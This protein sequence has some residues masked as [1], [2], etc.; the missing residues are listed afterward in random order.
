MTKV[1]ESIIVD[2]P[3]EQI[4]ELF[5]EVEIIPNVIS[6]VKHVTETG[7]GLSRWDVELLGK[8]RSL[9]LR[10]TEVNEGRSMRWVSANPDRTF[11]IEARTEPKGAT[12]A[13]WLDVE[14]DAG[15]AVE[16]MGLAKPIAI[17][18]IKGELANAKRYLE[19]RLAA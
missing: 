11:S 5:R 4:F 12:T 17:A 14:F 19:Q 18:A 6:F 3:A 8:Q 2:A 16:K 7:P 9:D 1:A 10:L 15:G 13:L